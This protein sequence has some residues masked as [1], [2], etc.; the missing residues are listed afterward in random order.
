MATTSSFAKAK[1]KTLKIRTLATSLCGLLTAA[2]LNVN[3]QT[4][5]DTVTVFKPHGQVWGAA[6]GD[7]DYKANADGAN[8][9]VNQYSGVPKNN[10]MFQWRRIYL[11]YKYEISEKFVADFLVSAE[12]DYQAGVLGQT[13]NSVNATKGTLALGNNGDI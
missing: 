4:P 13:P 10:N 9:G 7:F 5:T 3:G 12:N 1:L 11:G 8:R 6:F 2:T